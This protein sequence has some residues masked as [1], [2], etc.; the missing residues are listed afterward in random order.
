MFH[1]WGVPPFM[2]ALN[3]RI[4]MLAGF[5]AALGA[6]GATAQIEKP[7]SPEGDTVNMGVEWDP[8]VFSLD[9]EAEGVVV[10]VTD[11]TFGVPRY[12]VHI[13][14]APRDW[15]SIEEASQ[16]AMDDWFTQGLQ[17][18][19]I[20]A[21]YTSETTYGWMHYSNL[22]NA[23]R[24]VSI[25]QFAKS[26]DDP[27]WLSVSIS[28]DQQAFDQIAPEDAFAAVTLNGESILIA[29]EPETMLDDIMASFAAP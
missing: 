21:E 4:V 8:E 28:I 24:S 22:E 29:A 2:K 6:K 12:W 27:D 23:E 20:S 18:S 19:V 1:V 13:S 15:T 3:R 7:S 16:R 5:G 9:S 25:F 10:L 14:T 11:P 17:G 26:E